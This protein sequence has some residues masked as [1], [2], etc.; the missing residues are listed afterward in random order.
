MWLSGSCT[1]A[2]STR[3]RPR[4]TRLPSRERRTPVALKSKRRRWAAGTAKPFARSLPHGSGSGSSSRPTLV[5]T[6]YASR[7]CPRRARPAG[8]RRGRARSGAPCRRGGTRPPRRRRRSPLQSPDPRGCRG[9]RAVPCRARGRSRVRRCGR[10]HRD[11]TVAHSGPSG[12]GD[13]PQGFLVHRAARA[14]ADRHGVAT[15]AHHDRVDE[16][17]VQVVDVFDHAVVE[18][19]AYRHE[20][21]HRQ[22]LREPHSPTPPACGQTGLPNF[23]ASKRIATFSLTPAT[24]AASIW[25]KE[26]ASA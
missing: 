1:R 22:V 24:R 23:A 11:V 3:S 2:T 14:R 16:V 9:C 19:A 21:E 25:T 5:D 12:E 13:V 20:V 15:V 8:A 26:S 18:R 7:G 10:R 4:R 6:A 17:L